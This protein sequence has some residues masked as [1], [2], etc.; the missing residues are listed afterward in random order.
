MGTPLLIIGLIF[1]GLYLYERTRPEIRVET[2][3]PINRYLQHPLKDHAAYAL[4]NQ[5]V[6]AKNEQ[7]VSEKL[8][9]ALKKIHVG[10][11]TPDGRQILAGAERSQNDF[12]LYDFQ[13]KILAH[14]F[15]LRNGM[16][17]AN[18]TRMLGKAFLKLEEPSEMEPVLN[19]A[20]VQRFRE[21]QQKPDDPMSFPILLADGLARQQVEPYSLDETHRYESVVVDP[22]QSF[23]IML[24]FFTRPPAAK[25][26]SPKSLNWLPSL[27]TT[28]Y[29]QGSQH[30]CD[31]ILGDEGQGYWG[32]GTDIFTEAGQAIPKWGGKAVE[33]VG[34][35][36]GVFGAMGDLLI[37]YGMNITLTPDPYTIHLLHGEGNDVELLNVQAIVTFDSQ[38][39]HEDILK[40]GWI[41][42]KQLPSNGPLKDVEL[43]W[44]F[45]PDLQPRLHMSSE[46]LRGPNPRIVATSGGLRTLT[47]AAGASSFMIEPNTCPNKGE[48]RIVGQDYLAKVTARY[49]TRSIPSPTQLGFGLILKMGPGAI[50]YIMNGRNAYTMFRAEWHEKEPKKPHY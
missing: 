43:K 4:A 17:M 34:D 39:V 20:I 12:F 3:K 26:P 15:F 25:A 37:L 19:S 27:V 5:I 24:E 16:V 36:T 45:Y 11:Y 31:G 29:A 28:A 10:I 8:K 2:P 46:M 30:P 38:G 6:G 35:V 1:G 32:R 40:C 23:L 18:H 7:E 9:E 47:N 48:K 41:V 21:A 50:E 42:G 49:V 33:F 22:I 44:D 13:L 14:A